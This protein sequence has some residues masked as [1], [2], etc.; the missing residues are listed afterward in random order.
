MSC[1]GCPQ[2]LLFLHCSTSA[3]GSTS[4]AHFVQDDYKVNRRL[5]LNL[6][7]RYD[8]F[9][10]LVEVNNKQSNFDYQTAQ[11]I[12]ANRNGASRGLVTPDHL[13]FAPRI[14]L[15]FSPFAGG[16]T[17]IRSAY[18]IFYSGQE[19]RTA[20]G[21]QLAYNIPFYYQPFFIS[22]GIT[23]VL[24]VP[25]GFPPVDPANAVNPP[26]TSVDTRL[27]T[28]YYQEWNFAVQQALPSAMSVELAYAGSKGTHLQVLTDPNQVPVPGPGDIQSRRPYPQY[29]PFAAIQNRGNSTYNALQFKVEKRYSHGLSFLSAF[30]YSRAIN[31]LPEICCN[32]PYPQNSFDL[33]AEKGLADFDQRL[34]WVTSFDYE[35]PFGRGRR[36]LT[37]NRLLDLAFGGWHL[38][39]IYTLASGFPFSPLLGYD[40]SNTGDVG[41]V[42]ADRI[43]DGNLPGVSVTQ[44]LVRCQCISFAGRLYIR[45]LRAQ[46]SYRPRRELARR[47][48]SQ[49]VRNDGN[50][51]SRVPRGVLQHAEP[52]EF[53]TAGQFHR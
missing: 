25:Q 32:T 15:A 10:P 22:D 35:L 4:R 7:V 40:P 45:E 51:A 43:A 23:P 27:K 8:Y 3:T 13:N 41:V 20:G 49:R 48:D 19:I 30:T 44:P 18:G 9:S 34:R 46:R 28:P 24:T 26:V 38:G 36:Y 1:W 6:G 21:L 33:R 52:S 5:T 53:L 2:V 31:D 50:S 12:V 17:V 47:L 11:L 39:G 42:R 16:K 37:S 14:G 29:G